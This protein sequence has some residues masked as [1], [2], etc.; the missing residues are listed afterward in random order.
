MST[1]TLVTAD[2]F[3]SIAEQ[4]GP[5]ELVRGEVLRMS[6]AG[7]DHGRICANVTFLLEA[8]ARRRESGRVLAGEAGILTESD[9]DS[10]RGADV[11][12]ISY[13]RLPRGS[14]PSGFV[15]TPPE[16]AV[17]IVGKGKTWKD[18]NVKV[19]EYLRMGVDRVWVIDPTTRRVHVFRPDAEP[20]VLSENDTMADE[21]SLPGFACGI[22]ELFTT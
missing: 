22:A 9:P 6:P 16:L 20:T 15:T 3:E 8:W 14:E 21:P 7:F 5:C 19:G 12:Y 13:E 2:E 10:V 11:A 1:K 18:L 4:L 17:E